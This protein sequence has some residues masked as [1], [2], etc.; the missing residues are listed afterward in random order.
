MKTFRMTE[1]EKCVKCEVSDYRKI[2]QIHSTC[3]DLGFLSSLGLP[4]LTLLYEAIDADENSIL[5]LEKKK[6]EVIG[7]VAG[8]RSMKSIYKK[9]LFRLPRVFIALFPSILNPPKIKKIIELLIL[10]KKQKPVPS[11]PQAELLSIAVIESARGK[12]LAQKLYSALAQRFL[13]EGEPAFCMIVGETLSSAHRFYKKMG[14]VPLAQV[15]VHEGETST[16]YQQDLP[17]P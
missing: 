15:S 5:I 16:L 1:V 10:G 17:I 9:M 4:F 14:A 8:G 12:G 7:F 3:I 11:C 2:A 6:D 13:Q